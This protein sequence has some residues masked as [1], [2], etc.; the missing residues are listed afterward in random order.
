MQHFAA[1]IG[2]FGLLAVF[3]NVLL[4]QGGM[5]LPS[6][7]LLIVSLPRVTISSVCAKI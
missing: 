2:E 1:L 7:P 6:W 3:L 5:P 4:E